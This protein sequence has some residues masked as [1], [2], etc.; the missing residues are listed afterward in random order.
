MERRIR[1]EFGINIQNRALSEIKHLLV[2]EHHSNFLK[3]ASWN[4]RTVGY[5]SKGVNK[6][7]RINKAEWI[8]HS[9][10]ADIIC[11]QEDFS[12]IPLPGY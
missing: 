2:K 5:Y 1:S 3:I 11:I 4:A 6:D 8:S 12:A 9:L 10:G 7:T